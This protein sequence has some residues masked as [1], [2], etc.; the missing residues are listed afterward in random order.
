M[1]KEIPKE[2]TV[3]QLEVLVMPQGEIICLGKTIGWVKDLK[4]YLTI[5]PK[6]DNVLALAQAV[7]KM[8]CLEI[9]H[10]M[11]YKIIHSK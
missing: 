11:A 8:D 10:Q 6:T 7:M 3:C 9:Y 1:L 5:K 4:E 2:I